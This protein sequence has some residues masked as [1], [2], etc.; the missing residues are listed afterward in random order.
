MQHAARRGY[1]DMLPILEKEKRIQ[2]KNGKTALMYAIL[3]GKID[4]V[5]LLLDEQGLQ[6][7][8]G[9][10]AIFHAIMQNDF[11]AF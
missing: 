4:C 3:Y 11:A 5:K 8:D 1:V 2:D 10:G 6:D 9:F 7:A